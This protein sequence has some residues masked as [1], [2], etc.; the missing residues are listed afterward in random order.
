MPSITIRDIAERA[1]VSVSTVS[2]VLRESPLI[3]AE[4]RER[5]QKAA[6]EIGY[7]YNRSAASLRSRQTGVVGL[8][9]NDLTNPYFAEMVA[10]IERALYSL[11]RTVLMTDAQEDPVRQC[12]FIEKMQ[13]YRVDGLLLSP[14]HTIDAVRLET[15]VRKAS[16]PCVLV[17][18]DLPGS[19]L[20]Y[21][22]Y[23]HRHG[24]VLAVEHLIAS[25]H[26]RIALM[27]GFHT[28][29]VG[30]ERVKGYRQA[31][32]GA[33]IPHDPALDI[34][35]PLTRQDGMRIIDQVLSR[36][37]PPTA[38]ACANDVFAI[39][40]ML[41]LRRRGLEAGRDFAVTGNDNIAEAALWTPSLSTVVTDF[42]VIGREAV[43]ML[44]ERI[45]CPSLPPRR[46]VLPVHL[47]VRDSSQA[48]G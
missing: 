17:S 16:M 3:K 40:V 2:L 31:L 8:C 10:G 44:Q 19:G 5:V 46:L 35:S 43:G 21:A 47:E 22:G 30:S 23:D 4:T 28:T 6:A 25:G 11:G 38:A 37:H 20:D 18:R 45:E 48:H 41:G 12:A 27:G 24:M 29:W 15:L 39:G 32:A 13:E 14:A 36:P 1:R 7:V 34:E 26:R 9:V 42:E 33:G